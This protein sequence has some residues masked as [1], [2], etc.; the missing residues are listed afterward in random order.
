M[1]VV[2]L[3][4]PTAR[5]HPPDGDHPVLEAGLRRRVS[6]EVRFD[7]DARAAYST[8]AS[9]YRQVPIGVVC[10]ADVDDAVDAVE[11]VRVCHD[12]DVP[13]LSRGGGTS[14]GGDPFVT[15]SSRQSRDPSAV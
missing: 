3:P 1:A 6:G 14:L 13:V 11:A 8:D 12:H 9:N 5:R 4:T 7:A 15:P 2:S 10:P